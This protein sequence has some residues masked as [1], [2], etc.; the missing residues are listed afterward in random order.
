MFDRDRSIRRHATRN[1][2]DESDVE[3]ARE[4]SWIEQLYD[5]A[6]CKSFSGYGWHGQVERACPHREASGVKPLAKQAS[7]LASESELTGVS[8]ASHA[9]RVASFVHY[10]TR[11][12]EAIVSNLLFVLAFFFCLPLFFSVCHCATDPISVCWLHRDSPKVEE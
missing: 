1:S 6:V 7:V 9:A 2:I 10:R 12:C 5:H 4:Y 11:G 3:L 8:L